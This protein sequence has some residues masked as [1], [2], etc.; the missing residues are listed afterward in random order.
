M[1]KGFYSELS[2][3]G[4]TLRRNIVAPIE[5]RINMDRLKEARSAREAAGREAAE[6]K[7][8]RHSAADKLP[9]IFKG[10]KGEFARDAMKGGEPLQSIASSLRE[11]AGKGTKPPKPTLFEELREFQQV[12]KQS[13]ENVRKMADIY[14]QDPSNIQ[15]MQNYKDSLEGHKALNMFLATK[16]KDL[17][18]STIMALAGENNEFVKTMSP[19]NVEAM[20]TLLNASLKENLGVGQDV[21][22][23]LKNTKEVFGIDIPSLD[24]LPTWADLGRVSLA[25]QADNWGGTRMVSTEQDK[26]DGEDPTSLAQDEVRA[27][28]HTK[29]PEE[30]KR[31]V[32]NPDIPISGRTLAA[33]LLKHVEFGRIVQERIKMKSVLGSEKDLE[34]ISKAKVTTPVGKRAQRKIR[35]KK[36]SRTITKAK[37]RRGN[38]LGR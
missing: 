9:E 15:A 2:H 32:N 6:K 10:P 18:S 31:I 37:M 4:E 5:T 12:S 1:G 33:G 20:G 17:Q 19:G 26:K 21:M 14:A 34:R 3:T 7:G 11:K 24:G 16:D 28:L 29:D 38:W 35:H 30:L 25:A 8:Y 13:R 23:G 27:I 36:L 22:D